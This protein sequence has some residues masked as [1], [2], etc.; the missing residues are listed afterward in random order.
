M[1]TLK[2]KTIKDT[3]IQVCISYKHLLGLE[4]IYASKWEV[5]SIYGVEREALPIKLCKTLITCVLRHGLVKFTY[6]E[7]HQKKNDSCHLQSKNISSKTC[8]SQTSLCLTYSLN[9]AT[10]CVLIK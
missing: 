7:H 1:E 2:I 6:V 9:E 3:L 4:E 8:I 5:Q 10:N